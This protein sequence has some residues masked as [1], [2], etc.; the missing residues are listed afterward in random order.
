MM[1][2]PV[3]TRLAN[4]AR[5]S[6]VR[7]LSTRQQ[8]QNDERTCDYERFY[9]YPPEPGFVK[10]SPFENIN[11]PNCTI[12]QYVW[13]NLREWENRV[14]AV[15]GITDRQ[16]TYA[17]MRD[18]SAALAVRLQKMGYK[19]GDA[20][21]VCIPNFPEFPIAALGALEAGLVVTTVN[22]IYTPEEICRQLMDA[23]AK[24]IITTVDRFD[25]VKEACAL[26]KTTMRIATIR[27]RATE[28]LPEGAIDFAE[29]INPH[30]VDF[31]ALLR[32]NTTIEDIAFLPYSSGTTGLPK[33][34][35]L[36]HR[37]IT[38]NSEMLK[39]KTD[40]VPIVHETTKDFQDV[41]PCVLP[42][43]HIYGLT[44]TLLSKLAL[45]CKI[46]T[47]PRFHPD[48]FLNV[49]MK[50]KGSVL[51]LVPPIIIML[52]HND[53]VK[54]HHTESIRIVMSGAAPMGTPD[55]ERFTARAPGAEFVQGY[56]LTETS[57]VVLMSCV[58]S[59]KYAAVGH[60][61][62]NTQAKVVDLSDP[63]RTGLG[64]NTVGELLIRGPQVMR[65]YHN[66][67]EATDEMLLE[68]GWLRTGDLA[69]YDETDHFY[70]TDRLK[71]LIK[72]K[73]FQVPPAELEELLRDHPKVA[74]AAVIGIPHALSGE[75]PRAF[76]VA[77]KGNEVTEKELQ[78]YV[79]GKVASYKRLD[80]GVEFLEAIPKSA[81]GK[82]LRRELKQK[83]C[84]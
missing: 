47:L 43:F 18:H 71:E 36:T 25:A 17:E 22:P 79:A 45:G 63:T 53:K 78:E 32:P 15:C 59:K 7:L 56:G 20:I 24:F 60:P 66:R 21:A 42:F 58:G 35:E 69:Y 1:S 27:H 3:S 19:P 29:L 8:Q 80:G 65:G 41:L 57:P 14:A 68:D 44:V 2:I 62:P 52:G 37:N 48:S 4:L 64:P 82:I 26:T 50:Y 28:I 74:D 73:G 61:V 51:H 10:N 11:I 84:S 16:Y 77:K 76:I 34:V 81:T 70:I 67:K 6:C 55:A 31:S 30:G 75:V 12:D 49:M 40:G 13:S 46:V 5:R 83:Y 9:S 23:D 39:A 38:S 72:V 54:P 33:G